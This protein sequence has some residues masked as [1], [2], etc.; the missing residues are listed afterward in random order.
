ME[1]NDRTKSNC[2]DV[3][4]THE[5]EENS[6]IAKSSERVYFP[7]TN[8]PIKKHNSNSSFPVQSRHDPNTDKGTESITSSE[9]DKR[10][11]LFSQDIETSNQFGCQ[12]YRYLSDEEQYGIF[13][14]SSMLIY[15]MLLILFCN[16]GMLF[17]N[18]TL[19]NDAYSHATRELINGD[20]VRQ[21]P[22]KLYDNNCF[23]VADRDSH[24]IYRIDNNQR[25]L[26]FY[27]CSPTAKET[28]R[29][30][31]LG[32]YTFSHNSSMIYFH[33]LYLDT[34][35][36]KQSLI[37]GPELVGNSHIQLPKVRQMLHP[38]FN[39]IVS[40]DDIPSDDFP[41][42]QLYIKGQVM[43]ADIMGTK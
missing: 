34:K 23:E 6:D 41:D 31:C 10:D 13:K 14:T 21:C 3:F 2:N 8:V 37:V 24:V 15:L 32:E 27:H 11:L 30:K 5:K 19:S 40:F 16:I 12:K 43:I 1:Q 42:H 36:N 35:E 9:T 26:N 38:P 18:F 25:V 4:D 28:Q 39:W 33:R 22:D 7:S 29:Y 20:I 17:T